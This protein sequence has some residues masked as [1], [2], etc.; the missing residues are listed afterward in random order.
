[1]CHLKGPTEKLVLYKRIS[2]LVNQKFSFLNLKSITIMKRAKIMLTA[3]ALFAVVGGALAVKVK[4]VPQ[5]WCVESTDAPG[6]CSVLSNIGLKTTAAPNGATA[7]LRT[8]VNG[9][10]PL[11]ACLQIRVTTT[12]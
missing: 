2:N 11:A 7:A 9:L 3:I 4:R 5:A 10:C 1:M 6:V 8:P 12:M